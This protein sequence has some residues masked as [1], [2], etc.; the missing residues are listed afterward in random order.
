MAKE[1]LDKPTFQHI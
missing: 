1:W